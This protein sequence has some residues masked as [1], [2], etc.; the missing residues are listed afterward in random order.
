MSITIT[1]SEK[2][3]E[4]IRRQAAK[5]GQEVSEIVTNLVEEVWEERFPDE[6]VNGASEEYVNPF[7]PFIGMGASGKTDTSTRYK[8][9]LMD[10]I[11]KRGG[12]GGS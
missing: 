7:I 11:D 5:V 9:I 1:V 3:E 10:E 4:K 12:F 8:E 6:D 2:T